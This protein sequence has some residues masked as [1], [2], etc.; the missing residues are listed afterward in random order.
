MITIATAMIGVRENAVIN[1]ATTP[2]TVLTVATVTGKSPA[3]TTAKI[4]LAKRATKGVE[5]IVAL[6]VA[7]ITMTRA[8]ITTKYSKES[9]K[10][11]L[12]NALETFDHSGTATIS[13][14]IANVLILLS[15][16]F[17]F[18]PKTA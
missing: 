18:L 4:I 15:F 17:Y 11:L 9:K 10:V 5:T 8:K 1:A 14:E 3:T 12:E 2:E 16:F 6:I 7:A 13:N